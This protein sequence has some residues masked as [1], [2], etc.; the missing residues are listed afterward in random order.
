MSKANTAALL[1][2]AAATFVVGMIA[3]RSLTKWAER[4]IVTID[5]LDHLDFDVEAAIQHGV[6]SVRRKRDADLFRE[7]RETDDIFRRTMVE[8]I[9]PLRVV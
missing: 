1:V 6:G 5:D 2:G 8:E 7:C 4:Q 3:G 9:T